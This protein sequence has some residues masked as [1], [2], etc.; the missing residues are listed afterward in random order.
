MAVKHCTFKPHDRAE[1]ESNSLIDI[2]ETVDDDLDKQDVLMVKLSDPREATE[3]GI[4]DTP[5]IVTTK[6]TSNRGPALTPANNADSDIVDES[7]D[8]FK[9][10]ILFTNFE[11]KEKADLILVYCTLYITLCLKKLQK[12]GNKERAV[13][14]MFS[15]ALE[16]FSLPGE[17]D[18]PL[19]AFFE[20]PKSN[21]ESEELRKYLTQIRSEVGARL[22]E[23]VFDPE[24]S[25][26]GKPSK[27]WTC[28]ARRKFLKAELSN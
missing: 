20:K 19:N 10:N 7:L 2:L 22:V 8:L 28:F 18:F 1:T 24:F 16:K 14:E 11:I 4:D 15:Q 5:A 25:T 13:Q 12:C 23:R 9:A 17:A 21:A 6:G 27:W 3:W 26:D